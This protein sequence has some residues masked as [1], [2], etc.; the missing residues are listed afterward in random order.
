VVYRQVV[1][2]ALSTYSQ[3]FLLPTCTSPTVRIHEPTYLPPPHPHIA[4]H[5]PPHPTLLHSPL[6]PPPLT[7][8]SQGHLPTATSP[9]THLTLPGPLLPP[10]PASPG[11]QRPSCPCCKQS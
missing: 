2:T 4:R 6:S 10:L 11:R 1:V 8:Y 3:G 5:P 7:T 9:P